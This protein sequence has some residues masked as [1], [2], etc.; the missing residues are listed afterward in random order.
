MVDEFSDQIGGRLQEA[1]EQAGLT[2]DDVQFQTRI[3][4]SVIE[5][6]EAGNFSVFA[7]PTYAKSFLSQ[8][9]GFLN[10]EASPWLEALQPVSFMSGDH[11]TPLWEITSPKHEER[12]QVQARPNGWF[13]AISLFGVTC[14]LVFVAIKGY[15]FFDKRL[16]S[17]GGPAA[18]VNGEEDVKEQLQPLVIPPAQ[19]L[20]EESTS[21]KENSDNKRETSTPR[22]IIVR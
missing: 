12:F 4:R 8:Y 2:V 20:A 19:A 10:V 1:R 17:E 22:A 16:G 9:S 3:P 6:L 18:K 15:E 7:S 5:A 21:S 14:G 13:S 11:V